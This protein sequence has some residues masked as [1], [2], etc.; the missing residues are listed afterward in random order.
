MMVHGRKHRA[1]GQAVKKY[2]EATFILSIKGI[3]ERASKKRE[4]INVAIS[5]G[6]QVYIIEQESL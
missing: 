5:R 1:P 4:Q 2:I 6:G 3:N